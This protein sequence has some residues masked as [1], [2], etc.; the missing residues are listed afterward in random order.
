MDEWQ[1]PMPRFTITSSDIYIYTHWLVKALENSASS[2]KV[3]VKNVRTNGN[4]ASTDMRELCR[5]GKQ[6]QQT[7]NTWYTTIQDEIW[8][9]TE[10]I[11]V[12]LES[13]KHH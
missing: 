2:Y 11:R 5:A 13:G 8:T 12:V 3:E 1:K 4:P 10:V 6:C 9:K 7:K